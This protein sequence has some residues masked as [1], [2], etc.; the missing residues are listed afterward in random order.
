MGVYRV[1]SR[2]ENLV[3]AVLPLT[4]GVVFVPVCGLWSLGLIEVNET[5]RATSF[6]DF[7]LV[8][9][10]MVAGLWACHYTW[11]LLMRLPYEVRVGTD[12]TVEFLRVMGRA[13]IWAN[14][15]REIEKVGERD[16]DGDN[17]ELRIRYTHGTIPIDYFREADYFIAEVWE[18]NPGIT[19]TERW[20][21]PSA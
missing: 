9:V 16:C 13:R 12:G 14:E 10:G 19:L 11:R 4:V 2:S 1:A 3:K 18:L 6:E 8:V 15:I 5:S 17:R 20:P 7:V 21:D